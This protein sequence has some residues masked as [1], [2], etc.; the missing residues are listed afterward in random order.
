MHIQSPVGFVELLLEELIL[1]AVSIVIVDPV[2]N[3]DPK[4][5][6]KVLIKLSKYITICAQKI[7]LNN[8]SKTL[9]QTY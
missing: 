1:I 6:I 2:L 8:F 7:N 4:I 5:Q 3:D 9:K